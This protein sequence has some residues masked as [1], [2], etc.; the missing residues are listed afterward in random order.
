MVA[1]GDV[2]AV[3][4]RL[5]TI[6][7]TIAV[8][9]SNPVPDV[10]T[11][12]PDEPMNNLHH[13]FQ[14]ALKAM[15]SQNSTYLLDFL[16]KIAHMPE[17]KLVD[18]IA[19]L[20]RTTFSEFLR[21]LDPLQVEQDNDPTRGIR[22]GPGTWQILNLGA[23]VDEWGIRVIY[24]RLL[25]QMLILMRALKSSGHSLSVHDYIPLL[26]AAGLTS[27]PTV[28]KLLW[29]QMREHDMA[30]WRTSN[31]YHEFIKS[32]FLTVPAYS[33]YDKKRLM[34]IPRNLH[35]VG[36]VKL[37]GSVGTLDRLRANLRRTSFKFGLN[38]NVIHAEDLSRT[39]RKRKPASRMFFYT[40][41]RGIRMSEMFLCT[42]MAAFARSGSL[43]F[44]QYRILEDYF[45]ITVEKDNEN[46]KVYVRRSGPKVRSTKDVFRPTKPFVTPTARLIDAI[47]YTYCSNSQLS[48]A[49]SIIDFISN[50]YKI[51]ISQK[52]WFELLEWSYV[53]ST[54]PT[55]T[56]WRMAG[57][58]DR[59]PSQH[60]IEVLWNTMISPPHNAQPGFNEYDILIKTLLTHRETDEAVKYMREARRL[61]DRQCAVFEAAAFDYA[62]V[63]D[64]GVE[65]ARA[66]RAFR[67]ARFLKS[68]MWHRMKGWCDT[69]LER[70]LKPTSLH[71]TMATRGVP[72][73][74]RE[75]RDI[76]TNPVRYR[77]A[78]GYVYLC[79]PAEPIEQVVF[80]RNHNVDM[81]LK[82]KGKWVLIPMVQG[83]FRYTSKHGIGD[84]MSSRE[85]PL[86]ILKG[87]QPVGHPSQS[88]RVHRYRAWRAAQDEIMAR[89]AKS[90]DA[91]EEARGER[92]EEPDQDIWE[93]D[94]Y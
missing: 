3:M 8:T 1:C 89:A 23:V 90:A 45:G 13:L 71:D 56:A 73:F 7:D 6:S 12:P 67:R 19:T 9:R 85:H 24:A 94:D 27:V 41:M 35:R 32:R 66:L 43:R 28:A 47:V 52:V 4:T 22:I 78:S 42:L 17:T 39:M 49:F 87:L 11:R 15:Q 72:D 31:T 51:P 79:D 82:R 37:I 81:S 76:L 2:G 59:V 53:L 30:F 75:W 34:M 91:T 10:D 64:T 33:G 93:D 61:Y 57:L 77:T 74:I 86:D 26:R 70:K 84:L 25:R 18:S 29:E 5:E 38:R 46:G 54:P 58:G 55:S 88:K 44:V 63:K 68:Y 65:Y 80:V 20:P 48:M 69:L 92:L 21:C 16:N 60:A 50:T 40:Q 14:G 83:Q 62:G 36:R